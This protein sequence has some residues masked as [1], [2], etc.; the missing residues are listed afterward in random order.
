VAEGGASFSLE[1]DQTE[2]ASAYRP[3]VT[4][5][6]GRTLK[7]PL[8]R[9][10]PVASFT[11]F[12]RIFGGLWQP[13]SLSYAVEHFF[14]SGGGQAL[15]VRVAN[16]GH[17]PTLTLPSGSEVLRLVGL[18]PGS[19][20]YLRASVD[21]DGIAASEGLF[22][23]VLQRVRAAGSE[24]VEDQE[25][26]RRLSLQPD[27]E[28][29]IVDVLQRSQL[30]RV[31]GPLPR[32]RPDRT[33]PGS[34]GFSV[35]YVASNSDGDDG[36]PITDYDV[37]GSA[38][39]GTG[40][41]ALRAAAF[42]F[43]CVPPLARE[44]DVGLGTLLVAARLCRE[45]HALLIVDPPSDWV[46]PQDAIE[47]MR[48]WPFRS[49]HAVL[50]YP[51]LRA[52]DRLRGRF[53]TFAS[54]G[55][56]A[57][58]LSRAEAHRPLRGCDEEAVLRSGLLPAVEVSPAQRVR[59]AQAGINTL[60][61]LRSLDCPPVSARTLAT[62]GSGSPDWRFLSAR[63]LALRIVASVERG[64]RWMLF[65]QNAPVTWARGRSLVDAYLAR[66][67]AEGAFAGSSTQQRYF[68]VC[69]ERVNQPDSVA[70]GRVNLLFGIAARRAGEF[71]AW[72]VSHQ[73]AASRARPVS[74]N[75]LATRPL[76][77]W[78]AEAV[79]RH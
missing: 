23:L 45:C 51:R 12:Q 69:D 39:D 9:A 67:A 77:E 54:C 41:F 34:G 28:R 71:D 20:E 3:P 17:A 76:G 5:F 29:C 8:N 40:L 44:H 15:V 50:Y 60:V 46:G 27:S 25:I 66:F 61:A 59:L 24:R 35:G 74:V 57:G 43:L 55:A 64:T 63:R 7:G 53:E 4:A 10:V 14:A 72:L 30:A 56:A 68:V 48:N 79:I 62:G 65:E 75:R 36:G 38:V 21:Y 19:R 47:A 18:Q 37:I 78:P 42:D 70:S 49:D 52:F 26:F 73:P 58:L 13:S 6:V 31:A 33:G 16:G 22:N 11:E 2:A 1:Y 32:C